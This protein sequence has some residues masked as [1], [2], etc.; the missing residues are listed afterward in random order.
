MRIIAL[1][2]ALF[3]IFTLGMLMFYLRETEVVSL[4]DIERL[5]V[6]TKVK[7][8]GE[9]IEERILY[10]GTKLIKIGDI[11]SFE[12]SQKLSKLSKKD[13]EN[14]SEIDGYSKSS[15]EI[16]CDCKESFKEK[17]VRVTGL[18]EEFNRKRQVIALK[19]EV[20]EG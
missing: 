8:E 18:I 20:L 2:I 11:E 13:F 1:I 3:G 4:K 9:V 17:E 7:L 16:I 12:K 10:K 19:V 6:N 14:L 5:E 15:I